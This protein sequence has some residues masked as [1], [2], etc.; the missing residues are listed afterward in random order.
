MQEG[1]AQSNLQGT[2]SLHAS[3]AGCQGPGRAAVTG[4]RL[5]I[6]VTMPSTSLASCMSIGSCQPLPTVKSELDLW[7]L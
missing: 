7:R 2:C 5:I 1:A 3:G 6:A 4:K